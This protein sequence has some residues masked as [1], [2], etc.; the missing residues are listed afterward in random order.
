MN[1][2]SQ[3]R[4]A[5]TAAVELTIILVMTL[6]IIPFVFF[7]GRV[8]WHYNVLRQASYDAAR[9]VASAGMTTMAGSSATVVATARTM[10]EDAAAR[11]GL[12]PLTYVSVVC[13]PLFTCSGAVGGTINVSV[14]SKMTDPGFEIFTAPF[15]DYGEFQFVAS[16]EVPYA[17]REAKP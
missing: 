3:K 4:E 7:F 6:A 15:L 9:Y 5:G 14:I 10:V 11:A 17:G 16:A 12:E 1:P 2:R 13:Y 8:L